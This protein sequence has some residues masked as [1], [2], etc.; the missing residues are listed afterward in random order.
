MQDDI[1]F[2]GDVDSGNVVHSEGISASERRIQKLMSKSQKNR[3]RRSENP[4]GAVESPKKNQ[5][6]IGYICEKCGYLFYRGLNETDVLC[7]HCQSRH[8]F[9]DAV[10]P[11]SQHRDRDRAERFVQMMDKSAKSVKGIRYRGAM[12]SQDTSSDDAKTEMS[13]QMG[14]AEYREYLADMAEHDPKA[15][16]DAF[17]AALEAANEAIGEDRNETIDDVT[18][19]TQDR[20]SHV[21]AVKMGEHAEIVAKMAA[22]ASTTSS[23]FDDL[24]VGRI[25]KDNSAVRDPSVGVSDYASRLADEYHIP[26]FS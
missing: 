13:L 2:Y 24:A 15:P 12:L 14:S 1:D 25:R 9:I 19:E 4:F 23:V 6:K 17:H 22:I 16:D 11:L 20:R 18:S 21:T 10:E 8:H 7:P 26:E 5:D 3:R